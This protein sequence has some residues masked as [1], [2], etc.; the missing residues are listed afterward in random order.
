[1][2]KEGFSHGLGPWP[3]IDIQTGLLVFSP[4]IWVYVCGVEKTREKKGNIWMKEWK[5]YHN[6]FIIFSQ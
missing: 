1:M 4:H 3:N 6:I 2:A 5:Y